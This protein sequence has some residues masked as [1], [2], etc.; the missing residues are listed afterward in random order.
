MDLLRLYKYLEIKITSLHDLGYFY[1]HRLKYGFLC[2]FE[3]QVTIKTKLN[4]SN[5]KFRL[6]PLKFDIFN[7]IISIERKPFRHLILESFK[8]ACDFFCLVHILL[9]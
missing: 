8:S 4:I 3:L 6:E 2:I 5:E 7:E 1:N 9:K